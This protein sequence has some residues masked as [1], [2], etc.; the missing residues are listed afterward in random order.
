MDDFTV[1]IILSTAGFFAG[2]WVGVFTE[3]A[4][5]KKWFRKELDKCYGGKEGETE[6]KLIEGRYPD[7]YKCSACGQGFRDDIMWIYDIEDKGHQKFP[8]EYCPEC[9]AKWSGCEFIDELEQKG[10]A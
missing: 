8:P 5:L 3:A 1:C 7:D 6:G 10:G 2:F 9:G 4:K